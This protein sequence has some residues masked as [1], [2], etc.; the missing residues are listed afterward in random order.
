MP[1]MVSLTY[2]SPARCAARAIRAETGV[3][4]RLSTP[5]HPPRTFRADATE[6]R[7][8]FQWSFLRCFRAVLYRLQVTIR[9]IPTLL[10]SV[11]LQR[12][13]FSQGNLGC[14]LGFRDGLVG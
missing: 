3:W 12:V 1:D 9:L 8:L 5:T 10:L 14:A 2:T 7:S 11:S 6:F 4:T 13:A